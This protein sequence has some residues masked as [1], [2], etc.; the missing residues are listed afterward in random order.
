MT[1]AQKIALRDQLV[2]ARRR[3]NLLELHQAAEAIAGHLLTAGPV[4]R[5]ATVAAYVS[6]GNEPG[7][8]PPASI[9]CPNCDA[10]MMRIVLAPGW[11]RV[12]WPSEGK[13]PAVA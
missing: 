9:W 3:L 4:R 2:T 13:R 8:R 12:E 7:S 5:A 1:T 11:T 10:P 6:V